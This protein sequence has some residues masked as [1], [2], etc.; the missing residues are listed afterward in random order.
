MS[1]SSDD[2]VSLRELDQLIKWSQGYLDEKRLQPP[3]EQRELSISL[4]T[5][6]LSCLLE[7]RALRLQI[8]ADCL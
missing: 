7:L 2:R 3:S 8:Q 5:G 4:W 6:M 1:N